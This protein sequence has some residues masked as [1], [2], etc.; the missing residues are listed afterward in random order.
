MKREHKFEVLEH[1]AD[2]GVT[3]FGQT[4]AEAFES[5]ACGMF[6]LVAD[7]DKY[8]P[9]ESR[10][11]VA[12]ADDS[13]NLL[14]RFLSALLVIF[15]GDALLPLNFEIVEMSDEKLVCLVSCR[16]MGDD[17]EWFGPTIKAVTYHQ[18]SVEDSGGE[19]RARVIFDV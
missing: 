5:A 12:T 9:T 14:E 15:D 11:V 1:T 13:L 19:W 6:S 7:L 8:E 4:M 16:K 18:M 10:E 3:G 17:I 2:V